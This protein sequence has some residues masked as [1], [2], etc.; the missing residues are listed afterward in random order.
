LHDDT[1]K[2]KSGKEE[3]GKE[4]SGI[5]VQACGQSVALHPSKLLKIP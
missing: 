3:E 1:S 5:L 2:K 4:E